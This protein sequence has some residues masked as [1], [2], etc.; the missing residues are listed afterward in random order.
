[1]FNQKMKI[2]NLTKESWP[3]TDCNTHFGSLSI[4]ER[5]KSGWVY[6][7][8]SK[9]V[10][11]VGGINFKSRIIMLEVL[12]QVSQSAECSNCCGFLWK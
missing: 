11:V 5:C 2:I 3:R 10:D 7:L 1:M 9:D 4:F 8:L 6:P 12:H